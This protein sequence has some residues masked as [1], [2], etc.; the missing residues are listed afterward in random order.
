MAAWPTLDA[1]R[2]LL[3]RAHRIVLVVRPEH[4]AGMLQLRHGLLDDLGIH[5]GDSL[6][7]VVQDLVDIAIAVAGDRDAPL[8]AAVK[9]L[10]IRD[11]LAPFPQGP[12]QHE[13]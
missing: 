12:P 3:L 9:A 8:L 2:R 10:D 5:L 6:D 7:L 13:A 11:R 4:E 1:A